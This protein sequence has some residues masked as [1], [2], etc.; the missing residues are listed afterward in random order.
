M[1]ERDPRR[2]VPAKLRGVEALDGSFDPGDVT[3]MVDEPGGTTT[4]W[5]FGCPGCGGACILHLGT[6]PEGH[7][8][9]VTAGDASKPETA[10]LAPSIHHTSQ[11]GGCGWHGYLTAGVFTPC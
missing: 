6:G 7:T 5:G 11:Y 10:T 4:A 9:R 8:W 2:T 1:S 3:L